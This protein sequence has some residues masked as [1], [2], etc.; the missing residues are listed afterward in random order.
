MESQQAVIERYFVADSDNSTLATIETNDDGQFEL[1]L[2]EKIAL[3]HDTN[4][5]IFKLP[6]ENQVLG[7]N[8]CGHLIFHLPLEDGDSISRKYTPVSQLNERGTVTFVIKTYKKCDEFPNGGKMSQH[9]ESLEVGAKVKM[10]GPFGL[11]AYIGF[12]TFTLKKTKI[13]KTKIGII[14]GGTGI[15]PCFQL[16][17]ASTLADDGLQMVMLYSNKSKDDILV[18]DELDQLSQQNTNNLKLYH[19]LTRH[20][21]EKHGEWTGLK[22]RVSAEHIKQCR[23][24]EPSSDTLIVYCGP[25]A[26]GKTVEEVLTSLGYTKE[27]M[28]KF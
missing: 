24:P 9:L 13:Q 20:D 21:D 11:L 10:E 26:F 2:K 17:Q 5:F 4:K 27:M 19:T 12:G 15:T 8:V 22:G 7:L 14:A 25:A 18:K 3:T 28:H 6:D 23:F 1:E 16:V